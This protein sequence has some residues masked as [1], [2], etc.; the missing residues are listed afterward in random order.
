M[1]PGWGATLASVWGP[2]ATQSQYVHLAIFL[3]KVGTHRSVDRA[4]GVVLAPKVQPELHQT[5]GTVND[6][7]NITFHPM[8]PVPGPS[9]TDIH[10]GI[11]LAGA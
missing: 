3:A 5:F 11:L 9:F 10:L 2:D 1:G 6:A 7:I 8:Q 4:F